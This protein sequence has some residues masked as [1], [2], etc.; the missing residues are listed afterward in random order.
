[1]KQPYP[2]NRRQFVQLGTLAAGSALLPGGLRAAELAAA[3]LP[4]L[5][6]SFDALEPHIDAKTMEIHHGK[7]HAAYIAGLSAALAKAPELAS[8]P[9]EK[10]LAG[11]PAVADEAIRTPLR[12]HGGGDWN[13]SFFWKT[14]APAA[15]SGKPSGKL[16]AAIQSG[17][18]SMDDFKK[19]FGEAAAKRFGS[20]WAWLIVQNGKLKVTSTPNQDNPL[21]KGLVPDA[22]L[23]TPVLGLDVWEHAYY[24]HYQNRRPDYISAWW[25]VVN[26]AEVSKRF[27]E[28]AG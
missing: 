14:L 19:A 27:E 15:Q 12:N 9:L 26:W 23:G 28:S 8:Q 5:P 17:F 2:I 10:L 21:M 7:H 3:T 24:L 13:H 22:D 4:G 18:G 1:M 16:A 25:N 11:L 6:Y 20:G